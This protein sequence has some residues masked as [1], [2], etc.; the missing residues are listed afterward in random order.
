MPDLCVG[1]IGNITSCCDAEV[2]GL[3]I[4]VLKNISAFD[5]VFTYLL[6]EVRVVQDVIHCPDES[7]F[8]S[9][10]SSRPICVC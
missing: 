4:F 9:D 2:F 5:I 8:A 6:L 7:A 10:H 1:V 3:I